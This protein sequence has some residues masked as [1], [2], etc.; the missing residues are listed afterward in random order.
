MNKPIKIRQEVPYNVYEHS[1]LS[2]GALDDIMIR[3][4]K[5]KVAKFLIDEGLI[6]V[7]VHREERKSVTVFTGSL[8][9]DITEDMQEE[10]YKVRRE[11]DGYK[12][13]LEDI[14]KFIRKYDLD[15]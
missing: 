9:K 2:E 10:L 11:R 3:R 15:V 13:Q 4:V 7:A 14:K 8:A 1:V 6:K 5:E 12:K